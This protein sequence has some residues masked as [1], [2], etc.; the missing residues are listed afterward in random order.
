[1]KDALFSI[2][3]AQWAARDFKYGRSDMAGTPKLNF[4]DERCL[5]TLIREILGS[6]L[7][8]RL[9]YPISYRSLALL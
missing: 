7:S 5:K 9:L 4:A 8:T 2:T 1:M 3:E 6:R